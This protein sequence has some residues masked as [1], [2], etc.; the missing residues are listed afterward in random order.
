MRRGA[1]PVA[2]PQSTDGSDGAMLA[3]GSLATASNAYSS[4]CGARSLVAVVEAAPVQSCASC[5]V[6]ARAADAST[7]SLS[8]ESAH[9]S[10]EAAAAPNSATRLLAATHSVLTSWRCS[11]LALATAHASVAI[12]CGS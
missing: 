1:A 9:S 2:A 11:P 4:C 10:W 12:D 3:E 7:P 5:A 8:R 6:S